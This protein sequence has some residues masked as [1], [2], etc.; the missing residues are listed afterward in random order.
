MLIWL[1][2]KPVD[3]EELR[4]VVVRGERPRELALTVDSLGSAQ[5]LDLGHPKAQRLVLAL[6]D[7]FDLL[8]TENRD[9]PPSSDWLHGGDDLRLRGRREPP[10]GS[11]LDAGG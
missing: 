6:I 7:L 3:L 4:L 9:G 8:K 1:N 11:G 10:V 2:D 5:V